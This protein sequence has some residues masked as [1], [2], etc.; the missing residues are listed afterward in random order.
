MY[1]LHD[2]T[3]KIFTNN[4]L[5]TTTFR[6]KPRYTPFRA[7][8]ITPDEFYTPTSTEKEIVLCDYVLLRKCGWDAGRM[9]TEEYVMTSAAG[10]PIMMEDTP[11]GS[12]HAHN[13]SNMHVGGQDLGTS[14]TKPSDSVHEK[15]ISD[16]ADMRTCYREH[17]QEALRSINTTNTYFACA[18]ELSWESLK[19]LPSI[20]VQ[21]VGRLALPVTAE[22]QGL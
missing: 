2:K 9:A 16:D 5:G 14:S 8:W 7:C 11:A 19:G 3:T 1:I 17:I 6:P 13:E 22:Q 20:C 21:G 12:V 15:K 4:P 10:E 18:G